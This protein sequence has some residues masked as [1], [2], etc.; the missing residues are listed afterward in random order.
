MM[1][2]SGQESGVGS[3]RVSIVIFLARESRLLIP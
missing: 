3:Q 1:R 2:N